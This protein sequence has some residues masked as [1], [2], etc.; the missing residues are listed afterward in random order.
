MAAPATAMPPPVAPTRRRVSAATS[1][2]LAVQDVGPERVVGREPRVLEVPRR[3][4]RHPRRRAI[5]RRDQR[6]PDGGERHNLVESHR[7]EPERHH[8]ATPSVA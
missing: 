7:V 8:G 5:T 6:V 4:T 2:G 3:V 1:S